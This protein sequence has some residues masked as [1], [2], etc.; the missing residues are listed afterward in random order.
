MGVVTTRTDWRLDRLIERLPRRFRRVVR[1]LQEPSL[2]WIRMPTGVLLICGGLLAF[3]PILGLWMMPLGLALLADDVPPL[4]ALRN[5]ML[6]WIERRH[7]GWL[8][9]SAP[10]D[11][12]GRAK[13]N[14]M[15]DWGDP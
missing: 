5:R 3:L 4:R 6:D 9:T 7:P 1:W 12:R 8:A 10:G 15:M 13:G 2:V 11:T 14:P